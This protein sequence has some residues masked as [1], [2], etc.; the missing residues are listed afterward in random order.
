MSDNLLAGRYQLEHLLGA[1]GM[2]TVYRALDLLRK[3]LGDPDPYV[4][5]KRLSDRSVDT[6][7]PMPC[8]TANSL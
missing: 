1:G 8:C 2:S 7:M 5:V 4:A 3:A 6:Q